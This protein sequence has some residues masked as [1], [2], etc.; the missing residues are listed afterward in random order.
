M[1]LPFPSPGIAQ[2]WF[3]RYLATNNTNNGAFS[4]GAPTLV[5]PTNAIKLPTLLPRL[6]VE[7][8]HSPRG[9]CIRPFAVGTAG[10]TYQV[11][12]SLVTETIVSRWKT[13][14]TPVASAFAY[15]DMLTES[16][17]NGSEFPLDRSR[18]M[19]YKSDIP[20]NRGEVIEYRTEPYALWTC[21]ASGTIV[22]VAS[23]LGATAKFCNN[24]VQDATVGSVNRISGLPGYT[25]IID[26]GSDTDVSPGQILLPDPSWFNQALLLEFRI[27]GAITSMNALIGWMF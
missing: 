15:T 24:I 14:D 27:V 3:G 5:R 9:L 13:S 16:A 19:P 8:G 25:P 7:T 10:Q 6:G 22:G 1:S 11:R 4:A 23:G 20:N 21:T 17:I 2:Y 12:L 18:Q 26:I